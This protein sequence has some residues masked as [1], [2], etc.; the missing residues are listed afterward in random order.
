M[1]IADS[2]LESP[3]DSTDVYSVL[4]MVCINPKCPNYCGLDL[5]NPKMYTE[6]K[7]K[8]N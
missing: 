6:V 2:K 5:N 7:N 1:K 3:I 8:V 4:K